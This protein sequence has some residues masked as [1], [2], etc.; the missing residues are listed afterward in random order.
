MGNTRYTINTQQL[1]KKLNSKLLY[2][3]T[4]IYEGDWHSMMHTHYFA[5]L[6]YVISGSGSFIVEDDIFLV[7]EN[8]LVVIN[9]NVEHTEKSLNSSPLEYIVLGIDGLA[10]TFDKSQVEHYNVYNFH[11][12]RQRILFYLTSLLKE[13][14]EQQPEYEVVCQNLLEVLLIEMIRHADFNLAATTVTLSKKMNKECSTVKRYIDSNYSEYI[15]LDSLANI[16]HTNKY[17]L[18]HAFTK[19]AGLS[20]INYLNH[21]RIQES[22]NLLETTDYSISQI[23]T[24]VGFSSQS[25]F[26]QAF[27]KDLGT[28]PNEYRKQSKK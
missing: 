10:F 2:V 20:P 16:T 8:D 22:K 1:I 13:I 18:I 25:Y 23:S 5:E 24:I 11:E 9:P 14:Q 17:Y 7:K 21:K 27:K 4:S 28:S 26:S 3:S 19:Y 6:F 12:N 15:T